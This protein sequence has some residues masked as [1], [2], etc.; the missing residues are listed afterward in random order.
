[1]RKTVAIILTALLVLSAF[2]SCSQDSDIETRVVTFDANGGTGTMEPQ[3][4]TVR[5]VT[6]LAGNKFTLADHHFTGWNTK[7]DG[8]GISYGDGGEITITEDITLY[9]M[10]SHD[11]AIIMFDANGGAGEM[12]SQIT[13]T[14][15][16]VQLNA[17]EF[18]REGFNY[19]GWNTK[20]DGSGTG[21]KDQAEIS[22]IEDITL[23]A[24][25]T[26]K[27]AT[28]TFFPNGGKE[29][30]Y[31]QTVFAGIPSALEAEKFTR[32]DHQFTNWDT[33]AEGSGHAY[34][35]E[36]VVTL[37]EDLNLYAQW[38]HD[39]AKVTFNA[40][41]GEGEMKEQVVDTN[42]PTALNKETFTRTDHH[43]TNW[44][45][46]AE[47]TGHAYG[48]EAKITI[49]KD[50]TLYAQ[51]SHDT[52]K[53]TFNAN[54]GEGEMADQ[55][56]DTNTETALNA[57]AFTKTDMEF[58]CWNTKKDGSGTS[59]EDTAK[60]SITEDTTLYA[61]WIHATAKISF[62]ANN[63]N[64]SGEM[65]DQ[66][67]YTRT[68]TALNENEYTLTDH[69]FLGWN[70]KKDGSGTS[71][72]DKASISVAE[73]TV[74][75]AQ[76]G[77]NLA[78]ITFD[79]NGGK[80]KMEVQEVDTNTPTNL[81]KNKYEKNGYVFDH[82]NNRK[83]NS[84]T[85]Y[86]D[87]AQISIDEDIVLYAIWKKSPYET[88]TSDIEEFT[89][90]KTYQTD[91]ES[92]S[93]TLSNRPVISGSGAVTIIVYEGSILNAQYGIEVGEG[94]QL[95]IKGDGT[96]IATGSATDAAIGGSG[97]AN[98]GTV[99]IDGATVHAYAGVGVAAIGGGNKSGSDG[100]LKIGEGLGLY[101]GPDDEDYR[102]I[103][104]PTD[105]YEGERYSYLMT[106]P[107]EYVTVKFNANGGTGTMV[108]QSAPVGY[109][110]GLNAN[111]FSHEPQFFAGWNTKKDGSGTQYGDRQAVE[112]T[113]VMTLYAQ[114]T[115]TLP[116]T[117]E[118]IEDGSI[119]FT[120]RPEGLKYAVNGGAKQTVTADTLA[121][122][123]EDSIS[124]YVTRTSVS[125]GGTFH[126]GCSADCYV[127]GNVMSLID[128][129][130]YAEET[131]VFKYAFA[132][133]F[134]D[135]TH[136]MNHE[137]RKLIL[138]ATT[139]ANECYSCMFSGC[140]GLTEA[141]ELPAT[142]LASNCYYY[143]FGYCTILTTTPELPAMELAEGCYSCMFQCCTSLET[144]PELPAMEL[145]EDCYA[146]M[147]QGCTSLET[148]PE[149]PATELA[150]YCYSSMFSG[151]TALET[152]PE[153]PA[154]S[155]AEH[156]YE[157]MFLGCTALET[158]PELPA[159][160]L[161]DY[162]YCAMFYE[163]TSLTGSPV[164]PAR[165]LKNGCYSEMF[166][167]CSALVSVT[168]YA[169]DFDAQS[170]L[171]DWLAGTSVSGTFY[172]DNSATWPAGTIPSGWDVV[173]ICF[174]TFDAN[175]GEGTM[176]AQAIAVGVE[177]ELD[178]NEFTYEGMNFFMWN[179]DKDGNGTYYKNEAAVTL[180]ENTTLYA[181]WTDAILL[182][183]KTTTL[184]GG[185]IYTIVDD[186]KIDNRLTI[187]GIDEV[188]LIIPKDMMLV[189]SE[190][191]NVIEGQSLT[192]DGDG[193]LMAAGCQ[194]A[195]GIGG[196][197]GQ[198]CG[199]FTIISGKV[200]AQAGE[201]AKVGIGAGNGG[202]SD[203]TLI[204]GNEM[205]LFNGET[206]QFLF[207]PV[208]EKSETYTGDRVSRMS[209]MEVSAITSYDDT[210]TLKTGAYTID[211]DVVDIRSI[212]IDG[213]V[214]LIIP[215][216]KKL[217]V[218]SGIR[219]SEFSELAI[220]KN[221]LSAEGTGILD[222]SGTLSETG[223]AIGGGSEESGGLV[224]INGATVYATGGA[225]GAGIGGG[226]GGAGGTVYI[227]GGTVVAEGGWVGNAVAIGAGNNGKSNGEL[228]L[229]GVAMAVSTDGTSWTGYDGETR[230]KYMK[231]AEPVTVTFDANTTGAFGTMD[232]QPVPKG[233]DTALNVNGFATASTFFAGWNTKADG[234]GTPY[235]DKGTVNVSED[236][237]LYAIWNAEPD[238][239]ATV[240]AAYQLPKG[241]SM[242]GIQVLVGTIT[243]IPTPYSDVYQNI[244]VTL[245]IGDKTV[246]A[247]RLSGGSDLAIGDKITVVGTI[248]NY[249]DIIE[250]KQA[251]RYV[252]SEYYK[253]LDTLI[254]A[255]ALE[256][257]KALEGISVVKGKIVEIPT[258]YSTQDDDITVRI[259]V[260]GFDDLRI[261][262]YKLTGGAD[263]QN[264]DEILVY[265][266]VKNDGGTIEFGEGCMYEK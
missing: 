105:D 251:C 150:Q 64:A 223:A 231:T 256:S 240:D 96:L 16:P 114:W 245:T 85:S 178:P 205:G 225:A 137:K 31:T 131:E 130:G 59:Y 62:D 120:N 10:W 140:T 30:K 1:M 161:A 224:Y 155:L 199:T 35:D 141:P 227:N 208:T 68:K 181:Q 91:P 132:D 211:D 74:L 37:T 142:T 198:S 170:P 78:D 33:T 258:P 29:E 219:V 86:K 46:T 69:H 61:Q 166:R 138:P 206:T 18:T 186:L 121:V 191:I 97:E 226:D 257:G 164:L 102:F 3:K 185:N 154:T 22:I 232:P 4:I 34:G 39:T 115:D 153:H 250:F 108:A 195:A 149:L 7:A 200:D 136:I 126:I 204:L 20:A 84:G 12:K 111:E 135:N 87:G 157:S 42:T 184:V 92:E 127:Y 9:A 13:L 67:V 19:L 255:Y 52:A 109:E 123:A 28:I 180:R 65:T 41:G 113:E 197:S 119:S 174:V 169:T 263:L 72:R 44:D 38:T 182:T 237:T 76:W 32:A 190:G 100:T 266:T 144:A 235:A 212:E 81:I 247:Y 148:A 99:K 165:E 71:Y 167:D 175:E 171:D 217:T 63:E 246:D 159:T 128:E 252:G 129:D 151:C 201:G 230:T 162:C 125:F 210:L 55:V 262:C 103:S 73:D 54:G 160:E 214:Y 98:G 218:D 5:T 24:Q 146:Y 6:A 101:G 203:G 45:T 172:K 139:L 193:W 220:D 229:N 80:G 17:N 93:T 77:H 196:S 66:I 60:I 259:H 147:F 133:L 228:I 242:E 48:D 8:S 79:A 194:G 82:W 2:I 15:T 241:A 168:S 183:E 216:G 239:S 248:Q 213:V 116:L 207:G 49:S 134:S 265:G 53:V 51:W 234:T 25:W 89:G 83:D 75:Y 40:N 36:A 261:L 95:I 124:L 192:K 177:T 179:T 264:G 143:M 104:V 244:T 202:P 94:Q 158:A 90:G 118:F 236:T 106:M 56:M 254:K 249:N 26:N 88:I 107:T 112:F 187:E 43:F 243:Y 110:I 152:A 222:L 173:D 122:A 215:D 57:N 188:T 23:Y 70:T 27:T 156:C 47:G 21:Y 14:K 253:S 50:T 145:A 238:Q 11:K 176:P 58:N 233:I 117:L 209:M 260:G 163:C 189:L 221:G